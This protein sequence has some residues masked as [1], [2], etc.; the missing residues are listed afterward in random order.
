MGSVKATP[1]I[2]QYLSIKEQY[3]DA[4]LFYR[5][6][7]F[8]EMFFEDAQIS[9]NIL[10]IALTS[11]NK[12]DEQPVPM[13]GVPVKAADSY[14]G[15][16]ID[17][18]YKVAVCDQTEDPSS[19]KGLVKRDVVRVVTPGMVVDS[20]LL[21]QNT[22]NYVL[23]VAR[24]DKD[25]GFSCIDISTGTFRLSQSRNLRTVADELSRIAPSEI[26]FPESARADDLLASLI[27]LFSEKTKTFL[28]DKDFDFAD[29]HQWLTKQFN[30]R[31]LEGFG[32]DGLKAGVSA[33]GALLSY[34]RETQ[35][36]EMSHVT[37]RSE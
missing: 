28:E 19:A 32:C 5:M 30:T 17:G 10:E 18:G 16:L 3:Q 23:A 11:R 31:S 20:S 34:V 6:G 1:M 33:A 21:D 36:Q 7:D 4:I 12:N 9:A 13:C 37:G 35:K 27:S 14:I 15:K 24:R 8:Y 26:V 2:Q 29:A 22:N 25:I